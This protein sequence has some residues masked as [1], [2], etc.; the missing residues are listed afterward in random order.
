MTAVRAATDVLDSRYKTPDASPGFVL[1]QVAMV[2]QRA[3]R[4]ALRE[5]GLTHAQFTVLASAAWLEAHASE[6]GEPV[7]QVLI[8]AHAKTDAVMTSEVLRRLERKALLRR[9]PQPTDGR[10]KR[11]VLTAAGQRLVRRAVALVEAVDGTF[12]ASPGPE[13]RALAE[14]LSRGAPGNGS[15]SLRRSRP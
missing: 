12:F 8:S 7:T 4:A 3:V 13:L 10:A 1:W 14:L 5:V 2:W 11:I 6:H 9:L 15:P